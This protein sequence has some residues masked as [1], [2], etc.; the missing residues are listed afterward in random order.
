MLFT[1]FLAHLSG[2][3]PKEKFH[4]SPLTSNVGHIFIVEK[5]AGWC[6]LGNQPI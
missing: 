5:Q 4:S 1:R 6:Q 3:M 2:V